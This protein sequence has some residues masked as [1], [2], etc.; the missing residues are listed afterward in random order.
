MKAQ[1]RG[2]GGGSFGDDD[3]DDDDEAPRTSSMMYS[4]AESRAATPSARSH[5]AA[6]PSGSG[7]ASSLSMAPSFG[8]VGSP[9]AQKDR[10]DRQIEITRRLETQMAAM[11]QEVTH[12]RNRVVTAENRVDVLE[13]RQHDGSATPGRKKGVGSRIT[14]R[15]SPRL[16]M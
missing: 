12:L 4:P 6:T 2:E 5:R 13:R 7:A 11:M 16:F 9:S 3:D 14:Q 10:L 15:L 1:Q 8:T